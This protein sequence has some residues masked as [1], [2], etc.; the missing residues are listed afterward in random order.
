MSEKKFVVFALMFLSVFF[1]HASK[2]HAQTPRALH[3]DSFKASGVGP[4]IN[5]TQNGLVQVGITWQISGGTLSGCSVELDQSTDG[6]AF[7]GSS[8]AISTQ[9]CT[10][11]GSAT[12]TTANPSSFTK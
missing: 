11:N 5:A 9:T 1:I 8:A 3:T 12:L 7:S 2:V 4:I 6:V 10:S